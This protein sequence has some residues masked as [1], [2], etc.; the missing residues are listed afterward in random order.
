[1]SRRKKLRVLLPVVLTV[2][3]GAY[4]KHRY[5]VSKFE[6]TGR[7][8]SK[9]TA[10]ISGIT[11]SGI[12]KDIFYIHNDSGDT[13]RF[14][15]ITPTGELKSTINFTWSKGVVHDCEDIATG[16]GP[17]KGKNYI[18]LGDIGDNGGTRS[19]I[20]VYRILELPTFATTPE[21]HT[22][23]TTLHLTY[24]DGPK[25]AEAMMVDPVDKLLYIVSK[26]H[27]SVSVY[28]TPLSFKTHDSVVLHKKATLFFPGLKPFKWITAGS[29]SKDG[30]KILLKSYEKVYYWHRKPG[31][32]IWQ[33]LKRK[34]LEPAY[35]AERQG[36]AIG[37]TL[38]GS[39]YYTTSEGVF[40]PIYKYKTPLN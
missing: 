10:E 38:D 37:F 23:A 20:S 6:L 9:H 15:A 18:Y 27:D 34:P 30:Q 22:Q 8:Q 7:L 3:V 28:S 33:A 39:S 24:P 17:V 32:A 16:P 31:E 25:D 35:Q 5:D 14:F 12:S 19:Q 36:E 11:A 2:F 4:A 26:R 21:T 29:I 40:S 1:M 13:S